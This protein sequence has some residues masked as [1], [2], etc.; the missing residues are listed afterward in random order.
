[1]LRVICS[2]V[3][4]PEVFCA[5]EIKLSEIAKFTNNPFVPF[6]SFKFK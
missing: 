6:F 5:V 1:M 2:S 4:V 3:I